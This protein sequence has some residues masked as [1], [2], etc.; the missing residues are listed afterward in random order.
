MPP[1]FRYLPPR[2][3]A[4]LGTLFLSGGVAQAQVSGVLPLVSVGQKWP[5]AQES[6][7]IRIA[8]QDAGKPLN[9]EVYSPTFNLADYVDGRR[10]AGYFGDELYRKNEVFES[11]FTLS[12]PGGVVTERR[13]GMNREHTWDSLFAGGLGA[14]TYT[15]KVVSSGDG[16]NSF[17]L[18]VAAPFALE[19]SDFSVNARNSEQGALQVGTL[20]VTPDWVGRAL[21]IQNYDIDGP[22]EAETWAVLPGGRRV[23]LQASDNGK[24]ASDRF[25]ITADQVRLKGPLKELG[26]YTVNIHLGHDIEG[27]LKVWV[28]PTVTDEA[29]EKPEKK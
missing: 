18:R 5:Q 10:S 13:Y 19:T 3:L 24:T 16:K 28:V 26:L 23:N 8:P 6:Y 20:N 12:G 9:L 2:L 15:L 7:T 27:E 4:A 1:L 29:P 11:V 25:T 22:Q 14:G 17:A 21:D